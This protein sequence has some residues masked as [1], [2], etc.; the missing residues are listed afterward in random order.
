[1]SSEVAGTW[2]IFITLFL[3]S[4]YFCDDYLLILKN[5]KLLKK[6]K[7]KGNPS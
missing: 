1:M 2:V 4:L 7:T 5:F 6:K 3:S